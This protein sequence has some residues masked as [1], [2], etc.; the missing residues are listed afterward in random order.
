LLSISQSSNYYY[1]LEWLPTESGIKIIEFKKIKT[2]L[3]IGDD[4]LIEYIIDNFNPTTKTESNSLSISLDIKNVQI[5]CIK[6]EPKIE[7]NEYVVW[8]EKNI[9]DA[10]VLKKFDIYYYPISN[11]NLLIVYINKIERNRLIQSSQNSGYNLIDLNISIFSANI[12]LKQIIKVN[13]LKNYMIWKIE[14]NNLHYLSYYQGEEFLFMMT[15]KHSKEKIEILH[16]AGDPQYQNNMIAYVKSVL[17]NLK[18]EN[19]LFEK[20]FM[21]QNMIE[22][23]KIKSLIDNNKSIELID[24]SNF[25]TNNKEKNSYKFLGY[26]ENGSSLKGIDV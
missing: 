15:I 24:I 26:V 12:A 19:N 14:K 8:Y 3:N 4:N 1:C 5:S 13:N 25:I 23:K 18:E 10:F 2:N 20:V 21:Y 16:S 17:I 9:L 22:T 6:I 7:L 11:N